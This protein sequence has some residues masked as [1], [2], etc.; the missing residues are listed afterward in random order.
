MGSSG[1]CRGAAVDIFRDCLD[2]NAR[3]GAECDGADDCDGADA[4]AGLV[5]GNCNGSSGSCRVGT[6]DII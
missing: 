4:G 1:S 2:A 6:D 5:L 3:D